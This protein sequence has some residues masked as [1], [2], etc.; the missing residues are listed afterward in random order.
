MLG[1]TVIPCATCGAVGS[2]PCRTASGKAAREWHRPRV[3]GDRPVGPL[4]AA[5]VRSLTAAEWLTPADEMARTLALRMCRSLDGAVSGSD[6]PILI[7]P[8]EGETSSRDAGKLYYGAQTIMQL[9]DR[10]GLTPAGRQALG[11]IDGNDDDDELSKAIEQLGRPRL[12]AGRGRVA[13]SADLD[14]T[15]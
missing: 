1:T 2:E 6:Q 4:E 8:V 14:A 7:A 5:C 9:L 3:A 15:R 11:I 10:L 12:V 13:S